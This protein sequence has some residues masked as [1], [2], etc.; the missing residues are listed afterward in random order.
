MR[1]THQDPF[2]NERV[3]HRTQSPPK[4]TH[5]TK[6][7]LITKIKGCIF[8][9]TSISRSSN[10]KLHFDIHS[11]YLHMHSLIESSKQGN[12]IYEKGHLL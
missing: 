8:R 7:D 1:S 5:G 2:E 12:K 3:S 10:P 6:C 4:K 9:S 11:V